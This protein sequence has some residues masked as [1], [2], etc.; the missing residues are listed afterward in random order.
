MS[1][2]IEPDQYAIGV[3]LGGTKIAVAL[4]D[5][6]GH[7]L[8]QTLL[9]TDVAGGY[10]AIEN[11]IAE[12]VHTLIKKHPYSIAG[13]GVGVAGQVEAKTGAVIFAPNL[14]WHHVS[15]QED[16]MR[17]LNKP[18]IVVN[19][20]RAATWGEWLYGAGQQCQNIVC[21]FVGTGI[22]GGIVCN[23]EVLQGSS[24]TLGEVGHT[25]IDF[26]GPKCT[27]GNDGCLEAYAGG[28][29]VARQA[30]ESLLKE[31][32]K[33]SILMKLADSDIE[34]I[35][36]K[37]VSLAASQGDE[38]AKSVMQ[39]M[40]QALIAGAI[41]IVHSFNPERFVLGGGFIEGNPYLV[42]KISKGVHEKA[43]KAATAKLAVVSAELHQEAGVVGAAALA[44][45]TF[46]K[47][48][49]DEK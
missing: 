16:L 21:L 6:E 37:L 29:G 15:F 26:K 28:W 19:D 44:I 2:R 42:E 33:G 5:S 18:V 8:D 22:G 38:I 35:S 1:I 32:E 14:R 7:I 20:V 30:K 24:N 23:G 43:L 39:T 25:I 17:L 46:V 48:G 3:D 49:T 36:A 27:C 31:P 40:E 12:A 34:K 9:A 4:T 47:G 10:L 45:Y 41:S 13:I 11:Q